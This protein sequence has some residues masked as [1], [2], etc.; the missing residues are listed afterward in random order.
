MASPVTRRYR[1]GLEEQLAAQIEAAQLPVNFETLTL[2]F[3]WPARNSRYTPDFVIPGKDKDIIIEAKGLFD[4]TSRQK[5]L[6]C[7]EQH[8]DLDIRMVF[9]NANAKLYAGSPTTYGAWCEKHGF[10]YAHKS[11]PDEWFHEHEGES[12][13]P[14]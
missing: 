8:P 7:K 5:M 4:V 6:L 3:V 2:R 11:I 1:S 12:D 10:P 13:E 9:S 14:E